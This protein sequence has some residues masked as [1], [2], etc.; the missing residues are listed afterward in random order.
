VPDEPPDPTTDPVRIV[1]GVDGSETS[2]LALRRAAV[3]AVAHGAVLEVVHA[4]NYLDQH[5]PQFDPHYGVDKARANADQIV[6]DV[7]G[8]DRPDDLV[9]SVVNDHAVPALLGAASGA[10]TLV[11]GARG[12]GG[13]KSLMLGSVSHHV[14]QHAPCSVLVVR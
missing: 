14:V 9:L 5:G 7:L 11:V 8:A 12:L 10:L 1:V 13:F 4:W 3:E 6:T 2:R